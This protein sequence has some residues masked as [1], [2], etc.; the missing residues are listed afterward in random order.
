MNGKVPSTSRMVTNN[1]VEQ[2][3]NDRV[4]TSGRVEGRVIGRM[5]I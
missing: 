4:A 2:G 5:V 1:K 3:S